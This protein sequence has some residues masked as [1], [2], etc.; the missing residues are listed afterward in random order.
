MI[1]ES[2]DGSNK[3]RD[4]FQVIYRTV[5][6][7]PVNIPDRLKPG[8]SR[9]SIELNFASSQVGTALAARRNLW[10][11]QLFGER[12]R[13]AAGGRHLRETRQTFDFAR[14][15]PGARSLQK[16]RPVRNRWTPATSGIFASSRTLTTANPRSPT[17]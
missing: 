12:G 17:A 4:I 15:F 10:Q 5:L 2:L 6:P 13:S 1:G 16:T 7:H 11:T 3:N 14:V 9:F 8:Y